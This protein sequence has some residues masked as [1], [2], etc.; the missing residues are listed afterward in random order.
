MLQHC[1]ECGG[2]VSDQATACPHCGHPVATAPLQSAPSARHSPVFSV[3]A[4]LGLIVCLFTPRLI[5]TLP[6]LGT[7]GCGIVAL[8][9]RERARAL[10][11]VSLIGAG[12]LLILSS[13][14]SGKR[15]GEDA[16]ALSAVEIV[17]WNWRSDPSF[18]KDGTIHW[19][20]EV[21]NLSQRYIENVRLELTTYD[22]AGRLVASDFTYVG[23]IPPGGARS[24]KAYADYYGTE[25]R[26]E[27]RVASV[28]FSDQ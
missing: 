17:D 22:A 9:R 28:H 27:L 20:A 19:N 2:T 1:P 5:V 18:G 6:I 15:I 13:G 25:K 3:L 4:L 14:S 8:F 16:A 10:A 7:L 12:G 21:R 26:A 23:A 24:D 11:V